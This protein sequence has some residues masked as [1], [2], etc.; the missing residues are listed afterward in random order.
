V[1]APAFIHGWMIGWHEFIYASITYRLHFQSSATV[2]PMHHF[3]AIG[4]IFL[5]TWPVLLLVAVVLRMQNRLNDQRSGVRDWLERLTEAPRAGI[6]AN[7]TLRPPIRH[8]GADGDVLLRLWL[9]GAFV[10]IAMGGDWWYHYLVQIIAPFALWFA[11]VALDLFDRLTKNWRLA[12]IAATVAAF[13]V[14]YSIVRHGSAGEISYAL[15]EHR[16]YP[17]QQEV[18]DYIREHTKPETPIF[19][20][21]DQAALYYLA[22][23]PSTYRYMYDQELRALPDAEQHL[24]DMVLSPYRPQY[25]VGTRQRAPFSDNGQAFWNAVSE[26]YHLETMVRGV[27]IYRANQPLRY[28]YIDIG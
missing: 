18:A 12:L 19:V 6:V 9:L 15:F 25:I 23:R 27:P 20:A 7:S 8:T 1:A 22:D 26:H 4:N 17:A 14:P 11:P 24:V 16:G 3:I 21:F 13:L 28:F 5:R 2:G 10:G